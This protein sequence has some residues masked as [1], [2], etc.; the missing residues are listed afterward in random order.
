[1]N[2][3][4]QPGITMGEAWRILPLAFR[5]TVSLVLGAVIVLILERAQI[6]VLAKTV[7]NITEITE[8]Q[9][10]SDKQPDGLF[11]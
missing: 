6:A 9:H 5:L 11:R 10:A 2:N 4:E 8:Q 7:S 1:M 3:G